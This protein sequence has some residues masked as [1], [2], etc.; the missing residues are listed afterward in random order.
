LHISYFKK[1]KNINNTTYVI[2]NKKTLEEKIA[3]AQAYHDEYND[4]SFKKTGGRIS[5]L[6]GFY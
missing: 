1:N 3:E 5:S 4:N 2:K 6:L